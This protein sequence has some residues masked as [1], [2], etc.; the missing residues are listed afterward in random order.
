MAKWFGNTENEEEA[1]K[2]VEA[3]FTSLETKFDDGQKKTSET[4]GTLADSV[5]RMNDRFA[6]EDAERLK[7]QNKE[8]E[9]NKPA[10]KT[11]EEEF[12]ALANNPG[13]Y[14]RE[15]TRGATQLAMITA[16]KQAR[17]EVLGEK[18]YYH[19]EFKSKVDSLIEAEP[20]LAQRANP[21]FLNNCYKVILADHIEEIKKGE[22]KTKAHLHGFSD[23]SNSGGRSRNSDETPVV[24]YRDAKSKHAA[25]M[26]GL[27][28][29][30]IIAAAKE[31]AIHG[32]EVVA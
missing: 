5:K 4:L 8:R 3:K 28:D 6:R 13:D 2:A 25:A 31:G 26:F 21:A 22:L 15:Q 23:S 1:G 27:E 12:E 9:Q 11:A 19:G 16:G 14:I 17:A 29:K 18:E 24:E 7:Q 10:A 20:N 30:D 32:L